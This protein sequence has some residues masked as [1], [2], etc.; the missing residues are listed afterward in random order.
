LSL[1]LYYASDIHGSDRLWRKFVNAGA[2][3]GADVL[4]MGGDIA[5]KAVV[6]IVR[7]NGGFVSRQITG[8]SV[9]VPDEVP[10]VEKRIRDLGLY[11]LQTTEEEIESAHGDQDAIDAFFRRAMAES[12]SSWLRLAEER[13]AGTAIRLYVMLGNDDEPYLKEVLAGSPLNLD[14]EDVTIDLGEGFQLLSCGLAN[15]T[16]WRSPREL[17]EDE[18][19]RH[20]ERL[21]ESLDDPGRSVFNLHVPPIR[22][23]LDKAPQLDDTL[24]PIVRGGS[25]VMTSAGSEAVRSVIERHQPP[26]G[27]HGHIHESR[28]VAKIGRTICINP[29]SEYAEG[30][31]HGALVVLDRKK[32][33]RNYQLV[34]G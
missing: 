24:K 15:P 18:L 6:P 3:Y 19:E 21:V 20:L 8:D 14:C 11:P 13:L 16:P 27:L 30:V 12:L 22:S 17:P 34:S 29:G 4:V 7:Q 33:L 5:G 23:A 25:V 32:G 2:F 1:T 28:G 9:L 26:L 10:G 31:L